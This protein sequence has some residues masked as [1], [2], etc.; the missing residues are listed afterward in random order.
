MDFAE[1]RC[2]GRAVS[3]LGEVDDL[4]MFLDGFGEKVYR[5]VGTGRRENIQKGSNR[6]AN[7]AQN[8]IVKLS[9]ENNVELVIKE[10]ERFQVAALGR[11]F[12]R[13]IDFFE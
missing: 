7:S 5:G 4:S 13:V 10:S 1:V 11:G 3:R 9:K 12:H 2:K 6:V 8:R